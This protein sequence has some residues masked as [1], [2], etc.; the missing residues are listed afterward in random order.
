[1]KW[2]TLKVPFFPTDS[3]RSL[4]WVSETETVHCRCTHLA[5]WVHP[6]VFNEGIPKNHPPTKLLLEKAISS[7]G[8]CLETSS[9]SN[10]KQPLI[11]CFSFGGTRMICWYLGPSSL[12]AIPSKHD[13]CR[14]AR[15]HAMVLLE[16]PFPD[17]QPCY[18][19]TYYTEKQQ[20]ALNWNEY[21]LLMLL[22]FPTT[23][24]AIC[25]FHVEQ[26]FRFS[27]CLEARVFSDLSI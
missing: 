9:S 27:H 15:H 18:H 8:F 21:P 17:H 6:L 16:L 2:I 24:Y 11:F 12:P 23:R 10:Q 20:Q 4:Q 5:V 13:P 19:P 3:K 25:C 14:T 22:C 7:C 26:N 1:M